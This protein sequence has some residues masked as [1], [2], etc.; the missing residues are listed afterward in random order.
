MSRLRPP[1]AVVFVGRFGACSKNKNRRR[2]HPSGALRVKFE[3]V[4]GLAQFQVRVPEA[5]LH[6]LQGGLRIETD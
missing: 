2:A 5:D 1:S 3:A 4:P 6:V